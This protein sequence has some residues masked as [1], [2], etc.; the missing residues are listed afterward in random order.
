MPNASP[1]ALKSAKVKD[2]HVKQHTTAYVD[3][4]NKARLSDINQETKCCS[5]RPGRTS[6]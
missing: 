6:Y 4:R 2:E 5:S 3:M 1:A